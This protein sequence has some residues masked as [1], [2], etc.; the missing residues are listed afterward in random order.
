MR[1]LSMVALGLASAAIVLSFSRGGFAGLAFAVAFWVYRERRFDRLL[2][3]GLAALALLA[4]APGRFWTRTESVSSFRADASAMGRVHAWTVAARIN[5]DKPL[6]GSGAGTF[7]VA[8]PLYAPPEARRAFEAHNVFLQVLA[9]L[10][11][12]GFF[13]FLGFIGA[14][15]GGARRAGPAPAVG[16]VA[17]G[18]AAP[19]AGYLVCSA[20]AG[21]VGGSA[22]FYA[23]FGLAAAAH[24]L[25]RA[26]A[27]AGAV[28]QA[29]PA[30]G[31]PRPALGMG[32]TG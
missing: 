32:A 21:F 5:A 24:R 27:P 10:G 3:V 29:G 30:A 16:W 23:L 11:W 25:S 4:L 7:R 17:R 8:W 12:I 28:A 19:P 13:L 18:R 6:L 2:V 9:E 15:M 22:H 20:S 31:R 26:R 14:G 1:A